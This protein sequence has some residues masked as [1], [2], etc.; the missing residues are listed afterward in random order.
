MVRIAVSVVLAFAVSAMALSGDGVA[1]QAAALRV[2]DDVEA[3]DAEARLADTPEDVKNWMAA[4]AEAAGQLQK[5]AQA[6]AEGDG[7]RS[8]YGGQA[9]AAS[10]NPFALA[11]APT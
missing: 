11:G 1:A 2:C 8:A 10:R 6:A 3:P 9:W 4:V 5:V 7:Q